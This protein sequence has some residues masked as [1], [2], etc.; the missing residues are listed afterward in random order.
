MSLGRFASLN[1]PAWHLEISRLVDLVG[2][3][4]AARTL[5][6]ACGTGF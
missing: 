4:S 6:V 5:D 2:G 1:P 3:L